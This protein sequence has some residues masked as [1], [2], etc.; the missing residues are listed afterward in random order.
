MKALIGI[1][2]TNREIGF[3]VGQFEPCILEVAD[4]RSKGVALLDIVLG[5]VEGLLCGGDRMKRD[6]Q[7]FLRQ[8][9]HQRAH[10]AAFC[11]QQIADGDAYTV[12]EQLGRIGG[13][14]PELF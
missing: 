4:R 1:G 5:K 10:R 8:F 7:A 11:A 14:M 6:G 12:E 13:E 3:E 9:A 2:P